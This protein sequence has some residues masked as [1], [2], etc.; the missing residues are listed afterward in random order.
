MS[1]FRILV[2]SLCSLILAG[3]LMA[4]Q[5]AGERDVTRTEG[6]VMRLGSVEVVDTV[7]RAVA[8]TGRPLVVEGM[9]GS[10]RLLGADRST[11]ALSFIRRGRGES[12]DDGQ[13][14]LED[15][16]ITERGTESTYTYTLQADRETYA[17][18][19]V[20]GQVPRETALQIDRLSGTVHIE[21]V[22]GRL[23]IDHEHGDVEVQD[24]AALVEVNIENGDVQVGFQSVPSEGR[25][26]L[27]TANGD[28]GVRL[29]PTSSVL[30][31]AQTNVGLIR[32]RGLSFTAERLKPI[33]A[34]ARYNAQVGDGGPT[35]E[36]RTENGSI[37]IQARDTTRVD[38][39]GTAPP[40]TVP[41]TDTIFPAQTDLDTVEAD[42]VAPDTSMM[43]PDTIPESP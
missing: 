11:A 29:P 13:E 16:S 10:V 26:R 39:A 5:R 37:T 38:T 40:P 30:V 34:G 17:A 15:I 20:R 27:R 23:T 31:D 2:I 6:G 19:D 33:N 42:T 24:A 22:E 7:A 28:V 14:V 8:P 36:M 35:I 21:G 32:T 1:V 3:L 12:R 43:E 4:C 18:V 9:R 25:I 41:S